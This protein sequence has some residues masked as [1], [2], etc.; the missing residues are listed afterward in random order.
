MRSPARPLTLSA[1][2]LVAASWMMAPGGLG[3]SRV[4]LRLEYDP[5]PRGHGTSRRRAQRAQRLARRIQ[6]RRRK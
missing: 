4:P 3:L 2:V 5:K 6:R 1:A